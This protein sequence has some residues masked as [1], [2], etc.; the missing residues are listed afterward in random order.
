MVDDEV[1]PMEL[2]REELKSE[3]VETRIKSIRRLRMIAQA[4]GAER[5]RAELVPAVQEVIEDEDEVLAALAEEMGNLIE[6]VGGASHAAVLVETLEALAGVEETVVRDRAVESL[7]KVVEVMPSVGEIMTPLIKRLAEGDWFTSRVSACSLFAPVYG[8]TTDAT[9]KKELR[10]LFQTMCNDDTPMVRRAAAMNIGKL[11]AQLE[12]EHVISLIVPLFK[13]LTSDDQDS[14]RLLA[15]ESSASVSELLSADDN[16]QHILPI[17]RSSVED[18]SWRVRY[19]VSKDFLSLSRA[20][21]AQI[22]E[23]DLLGCFSN[24]LQDAEAEVRA[25]TA[26][27]IAGYVNIVRK[28]AFQSE[29]IPLIQPLAQDSA[30]NVRS[31]VSISCMEL[32]PNLG[33]NDSKALLTPLLT[34]FLRDEVV[35]VRLNVLK[36]MDCLAQWMSSFEG[37]IL[38]AIADLAKDLQWRVR[39]AVV[40][41]IPSLAGSLGN[42]YFQEHLLEIYVGA[43]TDMVSEVRLS[44]TKVLPQLLQ[45]VGSD[46]I[47][48]SVLPRMVEIF[49]KSIIYQERVN[50]LHAMR[51][52]A[53]EHASS[54]LLGAMIDM[55]VDATKDKIPNVRFVSSIALEKL[56]AYAESSIIAGRV[57]PCLQD[58]VSDNDA[59]VQ[60][61]ANSALEAIKG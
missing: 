5:T 35:D 54:E 9:N 37:T 33:E 21:G 45:S 28:E 12:K 49:K 44:A 7:Q 50:V 59:D 19:S 56:S 18:R 30:P 1:S 60:Y 20:M 47:L 41:S 4:L 24:L 13:A 2:L 40:L 43:F 39:E 16:S 36:R 27:H 3:E 34:L 52:L 8:K 58:L 55:A 26:K 23:S 6:Q 51:Q 14:V 22:T 25:V 10:D 31:A 46:Y 42:Q 17:V 15:I 53:S 57:R 48:Q 32:A 11:A 29:I 38:P 61:F